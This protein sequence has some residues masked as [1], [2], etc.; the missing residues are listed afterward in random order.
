MKKLTKKDG[1]KL[2][3]LARAAIYNKDVKI[4][5]FE[6]K[7]GVFV[8]IYLE[9]D[10]SIRGCIGYPEP[11]LPLKDAIIAA[12]KAAAFEDPMFGP[13]EDD[14]KIKIE[15]SVLT[16]PK[17]LEVKNSKDYLKE[18][19]VGRDGLIV[20]HSGYQGLLLPQVATG[21]D[22]DSEHFLEEACLKA[23]LSQ[24]EWM[25]LGTKIY[26][27]QAQIFKE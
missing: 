24:N 2:L 22:W 19:K 9:S 6:D 12:A 3:A 5:G 25:E 20:R 13:L 26:T 15:I 17:L 16:K 18:I 10:D 27:F 21:Q 4:S 14:I 7:S 8:T 11:I 23:G 1:D